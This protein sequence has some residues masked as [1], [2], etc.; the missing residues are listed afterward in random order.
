[1]KS[2]KDIKTAIDRA[3]RVIKQ[4]PSAGQV[5]K[6]ATAR[7]VDGLKTEVREGEFKLISDMPEALGGS[8]AGPNAGALARMS[9]GACLVVG[10]AMWLSREEVPFED[11]D[12]EVEGDLDQAGMLGVNDEVSPGHD[13]LRVKVNVTSQAPQAEVKRVIELADRHSP[14]LHL[15]TKPVPVTLEFKMTAPA[16]E[17]VAVAT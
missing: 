13:S 10:Y 8:N 3:A 16:A 15:V 1:M 2:A 12:V 11:I 5:T 7:M 9:L 17:P 14:I 4:K 6:K